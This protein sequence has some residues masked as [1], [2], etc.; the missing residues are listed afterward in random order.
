[1]VPNRLR[2]GA[3]FT[4][5]GLI[6]LP[7]KV[8]AVQH[9]PPLE[10]ARL[11]GVAALF[12]A[13]GSLLTARSDDLSRHQAG[14][15]TLAFGL[16][17]VAVHVAVRRRLAP[18]GPS[19]DASLAALLGALA[20]PPGLIALLWDSGIGN[21]SFLYVLRISRDGTGNGLL[22]SAAVFLVAYALARDPRWLAIAPLALVGGIEAHLV[23]GGEISTLGGGSWTRFLLL[24]VAIAVLVAIAGRLDAGERHNLL[25]AAALLV[26]FAFVSYPSGGA[27]VARDLVGVALM[28]GLAVA[29]WSRLSP[30]IGA[31]TVLLG[32]FEVASLSRHGRGL[33]ACLLFAL[34]G[35]ALLLFGSMSHPSAGPDP[36]AANPS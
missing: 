23:G 30:G 34:A 29:T 27:S 19:S 15:I 22:I 24:L 36:P 28:A 16:G 26:P 12:V 31:A 10:A 7:T 3:A 33:T 35:A 6:S 9:R 25:L 17:M 32:V 11:A 14:A 5:A 20:V 18:G 2:H 13:Y 1:L 21:S 8:A 4:G